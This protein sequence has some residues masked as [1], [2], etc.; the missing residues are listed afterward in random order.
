MK[1]GAAPD[2]RLRVSVGSAEQIHSAPR[3]P[4][5]RAVSGLGESN[6][7]PEW[8]ALFLLPRGGFGPEAAVMVEGEVIN[9]PGNRGEI[10]IFLGMGQ[11]A[12]P[13]T[14]LETGGTP[15]RGPRARVSLLTLCFPLPLPQDTAQ[16]PSTGRPTTATR[17]PTTRR[18]SPTTPSSTRTPWASRAR[19]VSRRARCGV[20]R[21]FLGATRHPAP[22][23]FQPTAL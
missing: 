20:L 3:C 7:L 1:V 9:K 18:S 13:L 21:S 23:N 10:R 6:F 8:L 2:L 11:R 17:P 19:W 12:A 22:M 4:C 14:L 15:R 5:A 16:S